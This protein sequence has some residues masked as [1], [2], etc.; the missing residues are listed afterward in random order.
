MTK[1]NLKEG[2]WAEMEWKNADCNDVNL[3][4]A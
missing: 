1:K 3:I 4:Q 2:E